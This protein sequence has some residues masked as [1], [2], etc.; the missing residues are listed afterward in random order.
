MELPRQTAE[1]F[2]RLSRGHF[3]SANS[4]DPDLAA[5]YG[6]LQAHADTLTAYFTHLGLQL[7]SGPGYYY[8]TRTTSRSSLEDKLDR[9]SRL[10]ARMGW[11]KRYDPA[12]G[13]GHVL[14]LPQ[15]RAALQQRADLRRRLQQLPLKGTPRDDDERLLALLRSLERESFAEQTQDQPPTF[16]FLAAFHYLETLLR[17]LDVDP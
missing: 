13:P 2:E 8:L 16:R 12:L 11:L 4:S 1:I 9:L 7:R 3:I 10:I 15:L 6:A 14:S 5:C 17:S